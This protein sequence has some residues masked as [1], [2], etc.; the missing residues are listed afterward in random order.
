LD[1]DTAV[2]RQDAEAELRIL[3]KNC[4]AAGDEPPG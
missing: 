2:L 1:Q 3:A 4:Q